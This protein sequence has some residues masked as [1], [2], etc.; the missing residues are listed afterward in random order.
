MISEASAG[1]VVLEYRSHPGSRAPTIAGVS[2]FDQLARRWERVRTTREAEAWIE[3]AQRQIQ[4]ATRAP[5]RGAETPQQ[6]RW[7]I[8]HDYVGYSQAEI[9][10]KEMC[11]V[12]MV[13]KVRV[14][15]GVDTRYG[16]PIN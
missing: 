6:F 15:A 8:V 3:W 9:A 13:R 14:E 12:G 2:T 11:S 4:A 16:R 1:K 10:R 5:Q 7:R